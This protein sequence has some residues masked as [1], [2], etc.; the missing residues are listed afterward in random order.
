MYRFATHNDKNPRSYCDFVPC[1]TNV[2]VTREVVV[3][4]GRFR[5]EVVPLR[6]P[7]LLCAVHHQGE[8]AH[9]AHSDEVSLHP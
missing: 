6:H 5:V 9:C 1:T 2:T 4:V 7:L 8:W 3:K